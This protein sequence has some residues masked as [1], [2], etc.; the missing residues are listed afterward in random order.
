MTLEELEKLSKNQLI[1]RILSLESEKV[2]ILGEGECFVRKTREG[3]ARAVKGKVVLRESLGDF[4]V[5]GEKTL[6][7]AQGYFKMNRIAGL[8]LI[9]PTTLQ[10]SGL[11]KQTT[12]PY[13]EFHSKKNR[14]ISFVVVRRIAFGA[15][16]TGSLV[17]IDRTLLFSNYTYLLDS[18]QHQVRTIE[19][20][21]GY[22]TKKFVP[23]HLASRQPS[24]LS[25][26]I[27]GGHGSVLWVD[28]T[29]AAIQEAL[30]KHG[31]TV[32][33]SDRMAISM[34]DR[35][36]LKSHPA[37]AVTAISPSAGVAEI[38]V[39]GHVID[40]SQEELQEIAENLAE[41][42][43]VA[44]VEVH[45]EE[46]EATPDEV[47]AEL[48]VEGDEHSPREEPQKELKLVPTTPE[49]DAAR[50]DAR[51]ELDKL[52]AAMDPR[53]Y[54]TVLQE[55][56]VRDITLLDSEQIRSLSSQLRERQ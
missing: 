51:A 45:R 44:G 17:A 38:E 39:F 18:L 5:Q 53:T 54:Y 3:V 31:K 4:Y 33:F 49:E 41:G 52:K 34:C 50:K 21:G 47:E 28:L 42:Q 56:N 9:A 30:D 46:V 2:A 55:N 20:S 10:F 29:N 24:L 13:V 12:N 48:S 25:Y 40:K 37:M 11:D 16:P 1:E 15:S 14:A 32:K 19:G 6:I 27:P 35:N 43:E 26:D 23:E 22:G 36:A 7:T 8:S